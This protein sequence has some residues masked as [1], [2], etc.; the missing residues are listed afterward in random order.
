MVR[1]TP[2]TRVAE[3]RFKKIVSEAVRKTIFGP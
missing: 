2:S 3:A 1:E